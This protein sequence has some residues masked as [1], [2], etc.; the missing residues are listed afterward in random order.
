MNFLLWV[1]RN[2]IDL[3]IFFSFSIK[4]IVRVHLDFMRSLQLASWSLTTN[5]SS[6][7]MFMMLWSTYNIEYWRYFHGSIFFSPSYIYTKLW[8]WTYSNS[9]NYIWNVGQCTTLQGCKRFIGYVHA[10][11]I[12]KSV[13]YTFSRVHEI[14]SPLSSPPSTV[15]T[16]LLPSTVQHTQF[17]LLKN[18][19]NLLAWCSSAD[20]LFNFSFL[21]HSL[22]SHTSQPPRQQAQVRSWPTKRDSQQLVNW[23]K[24]D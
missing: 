15:D 23:Q 21:L 3:R 13:G 24:E 17:W 16:R 6:I 14:I 10:W 4:K 19:C 12:W 20:K 8:A 7:T 9:W 22:L 1:E 5:R 2:E 18:S 11:K